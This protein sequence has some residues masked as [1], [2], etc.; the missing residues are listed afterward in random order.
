M[1]ENGFAD[2]FA[3]CMQRTPASFWE[4]EVATPQAFAAVPAIAL[5]FSMSLGGGDSYSC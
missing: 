4:G 3:A 2:V 1:N 5:A